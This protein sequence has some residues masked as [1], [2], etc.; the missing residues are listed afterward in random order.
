MGN[1][2]HC[3]LN[4]FGVVGISGVWRTVDGVDAKPVSYSDDGAQIAWV[5]NAIEGEGEAV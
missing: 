4:Y 3:G 2:T 5:L 1:T